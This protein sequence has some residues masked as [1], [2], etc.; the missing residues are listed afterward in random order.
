MRVDFMSIGADA[1]LMT[2][3]TLSHRIDI[4]GLRLSHVTSRQS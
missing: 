1:H 3:S 2:W 4:E